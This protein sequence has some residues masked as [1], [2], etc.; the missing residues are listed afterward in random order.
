MG[1]ARCGWGLAGALVLGLWLGCAG[2]GDFANDGGAATADSALVTDAPPEGPTYS[3]YCFNKNKDPGETD[4]D[5]GGN[6]PQCPLGDGCVL[7]SDCAKGDCV[8]FVCT[9]AA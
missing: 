6:C 8:S 5:C 7:K 2:R 1:Q 3:S 9:A 4:F